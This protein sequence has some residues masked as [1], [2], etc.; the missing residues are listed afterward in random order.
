MAVSDCQIRFQDHGSVSS[1][2]VN[3]IT[4]HVFGTKGEGV[5]VV[6]DHTAIQKS[7]LSG[8][9]IPQ[10]VNV[11]DTAFFHL[12]ALSEGDKCSGGYSVY[13]GAAASLVEIMGNTDGEHPGFS[14]FVLRFNILF[15]LFV[16]RYGNA[17]GQ[18]FCILVLVLI[19]ILIFD[20]G[21]FVLVHFFRFFLRR[22]Q[23]NTEIRVEETIFKDHIVSNSSE[24]TGPGI[25]HVQVCS[26][27]ISVCIGYSCTGDGIETFDSGQ[28]DFL[29]FAAGSVRVSDV[30]SRGTVLDR[31][32]N[33]IILVVQVDDDV[34]F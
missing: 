17:R 1:Y 27:S 33:C 28:E 6:K 8:T 29:S 13:H 4:G 19:L 3:I 9:H 22:G 31:S 14:L 10:I 23:R 26:C 16:F 2:I 7:Q 20:C 18:V 25:A 24:F 34:I 11:D 12:F 30:K 32:S 5:T 21:I 15:V